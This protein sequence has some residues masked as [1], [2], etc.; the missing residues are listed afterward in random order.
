MTDLTSPLKGKTALVT[1]GGGGLGRAFCVELARQGARV[2]VLSRRRESAEKGAKGVLDAGGEAMALTADV[3]DTSE[4]E[5]ARDELESVWGPV[6]VLV[7][8]AGG[9]QIG[10][11]TALTHWDASPPPTSGPATFFDLD[12]GA[13]R[14]V[15]DLNFMGTVIPTRIFGRSMAAAGGGTVVN[16]SSMSADRP[17][18]KE[19]DMRRPKHLWTILPAGWPCTWLRQTSGST[20]SLRVF[21][22]PIRIVLCSSRKT[23]A[24]PIGPTG[25]WIIFLWDGSGSRKNSTVLSPGL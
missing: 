8:A 24:G 12:D 22:S 5:R 23:E 11:V 10:A 18:T 13:L 7:N 15:S 19:W 21:S 20:R 1:G 25:F 16:I 6:N 9:H 3:T 2:A 14:A 4:V 17:M